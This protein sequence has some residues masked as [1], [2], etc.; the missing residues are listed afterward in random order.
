[1]ITQGIKN[2][3][4]HPYTVKNIIDGQFNN[5]GSS[6]FFT[7]LFYQN[8]GASLSPVSGVSLNANIWFDVGFGDTPATENDLTLADG[9]MDI[10]STA[11]GTYNHPL[12]GKKYLT[13]VSNTYNTKSAGEIKNQTITYRND[14]ENTVIVK[15]IG[16]YELYTNMS[17]SSW[18]SLNENKIVL[19]TRKVLS[20]PI[21]F[22]PGDQYAI[23]YRLKINF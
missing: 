13:I 1:M 15:E 10:V 5:A 8:F 20:N 3:I 18:N 7:H 21:T 14:T 23:T 4:C 17:T 16:I 9:N 22:A 2:G 6:T 12:V 11:S 19:L